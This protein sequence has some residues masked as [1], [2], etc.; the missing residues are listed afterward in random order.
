MTILCFKCGRALKNKPEANYGLHPKCF[1][2]WFHV[3]PGTVF[4]NIYRKVSSSQSAELF[5][6]TDSSYFQGQFKKY[7]ATLGKKA[8][9]IKMR[10]KSAPELPEV[11]YLCNLIA[12]QLK[13]PVAEFYYINFLNEKVFL[14][15]NFLSN[16]EIEDLQHLYHFRRG[17]DHTCKNIISIIENQSKHP[18][19][20]DIFIKTVLFDALIGNHDRH[21][22]NL[23]FI[24]THSKCQ[25]SPVFDNV[26]YLGLES[27]SILK[28]DFNPSGKI[29]T[30]T[31]NEP[32]MKD[33]VVEFIKLNYR[34]NLL[35]FY[36]SINLSDLI[37]LVDNSFC[38][39]LMKE[40]LK[41][42]ITKRFLELENEISRHSR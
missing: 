19:D 21:G 3:E 30:S 37:C 14:T 13:I 25:L 35:E 27:G 34:N 20:I 24:V 26:S 22:R 8:Y 40:A 7:A 9:I 42:L 32:S 39:S 38:S 6:I 5:S 29:A 11:E 36:N 18:E 28:A 4:T 41:R 15:K 16:T 23:A 1:E 2:A 10:E 17:I 33:Y 12:K 31:S